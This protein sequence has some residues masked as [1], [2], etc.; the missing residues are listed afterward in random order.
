MIR[1]GGEEGEVDGAF[2]D[3]L[4][5]LLDGGLGAFEVGFHD[6]VVLFDG[7]FDESGA[8]FLGLVEHVGR[9]FL[10]FEVFGLS[11]FVPDVGFHGEEVHDADEVG[12]GADG[13]DHDERGCAEDF[14]DLG[15]DAVEVCADAVEFV[16]V[17]DAGDFGV[18]GVAPVGFGLW[19]D[20]AGAAEDAD[21]AVEDFEGAVDFDGEVDVAGSV[22]DVELV[23]VPEAG[24][25]GGLDGD[26]AFGFLLHEVHGGGAVVDLADFVNFAGEFE[27]TLGGGGFAGVNVGENA[28]VA[29]F[30][31]V[32]HCLWCVRIC[33]ADGLAAGR[34]PSRRGGFGNPRVG[35]FGCLGR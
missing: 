27:N 3:A 20:A 30:G 9:D 16:D 26:A 31:E 14:F 33:G 11:G 21:A 6:F 7:G 34:I 2:A 12:F 18:V 10:D 13:E 28:D 23:S 5:D 29:I 24:G 19:F 8:V 4:F 1:S 35:F 22:D 32:L 15:D 25:C 17:D